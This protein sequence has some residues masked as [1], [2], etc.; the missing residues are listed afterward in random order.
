MSFDAGAG[1]ILIL[2]EGVTVFDTDQE[3]LH[4]IGPEV[5]GTVSRS[6]LDWPG[7]SSG[8]PNSR[9]ADFSVGSVPAETTNLYGLIR[10]NAGI[11]SNFELLDQPE[12]SWFLAGGTIL[13]EFKSFQQSN[14]DQDIVN[15]TSILAVTLYLSGTDVRFKEQARLYDNRREF[16]GDEMPSYVVTFKL[17]PCAFS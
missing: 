9:D 13:P 12:N 7:G 5:S 17:F 15:V 2:D 10:F 8:V 14:G 4:I 11:G 3:L 16:L 6:S 1:R